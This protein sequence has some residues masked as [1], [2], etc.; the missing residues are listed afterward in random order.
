MQRY[1]TPMMTSHRLSKA[2]T[3]KAGYRSCGSSLAFCLKTDSSPI[4]HATVSIIVLSFRGTS[5]EILTAD[6]VRLTG[7]LKY[8]NHTRHSSDYSLITRYFSFQSMPKYYYQCHY[9]VPEFSMNKLL[10][11]LIILLITSIITIVIIIINA[12]TVTINYH[13]NINIIII[14]IID[15]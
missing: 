5:S 12:I 14:I 11:S 8:L 9:Q 4:V 13:S 3:A 10:L 2:T 1:I 6:D 7:C 15:I